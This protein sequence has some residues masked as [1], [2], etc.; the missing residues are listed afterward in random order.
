[1]PTTTI[2]EELARLAAAEAEAEAEAELKYIEAL[3]QQDS[4]NARLASEQW[5]K[6]A[7]AVRHPRT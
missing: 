5:K 6:A 4:S 1:M 3:R 2:A 7:D